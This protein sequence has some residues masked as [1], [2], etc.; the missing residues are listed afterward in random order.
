MGRRAR[1]TREQVLKTAREVFAERGFDGTTLARIAGRLGLSPA[2]LLRH[3]PTKE[4]LFGAAM[5]SPDPALPVPIEF[6]EALDGT[7]DPLA[8][9]RKIA[10]RA[11]PILEATFAESLVHW[12][13][14]R[15][16]DPGTVTIALP[17]DPGAESTPPQQAFRLVEGYMEKAVRAGRLRVTDVRAATASFQGSLFAY[18]S[19]H[20]LFRILDPP[21]P[22]GR[23]L[24]TVLAIWARGAV[25]GA[26]T[27]RKSS[28]RKIGR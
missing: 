13:H 25:P 4:A 1:V 7:E 19:F 20:K 8:V 22:L 10:E 9:L 15:K 11:I 17:F 16:S 24:D 26:V 3:A 21:I 28:G 12:F 2:A 27:R 18:V 6:V 14:S 23:Y 5:A